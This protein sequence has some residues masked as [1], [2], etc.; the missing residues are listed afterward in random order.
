MAFQ[1]R[2]TRPPAKPA[3]RPQDRRSRT[4]ERMPAGRRGRP[5]E[6]EVEESGRQGRRSPPKSNKTLIMAVAGG[7]AVLLIVVI[8][9]VAQSNKDKTTKKGGTKSGGSSAEAGPTYAPLP[10]DKTAADEERSKEVPK[11]RKEIKELTGSFP[12]DLTAVSDEDLAK[13]EEQWR[14]MVERVQA[15]EY[16]G[17]TKN[18]KKEDLGPVQLMW[19]KVREEK[20]ERKSKKS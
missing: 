12:A 15:E 19:Q 3:A 1:R 4:T 8:I 14:A 7:A 6:E 20:G 5:R 11:I 10:P 18:D 9:A 16:S 13:L 17:Y 2:P